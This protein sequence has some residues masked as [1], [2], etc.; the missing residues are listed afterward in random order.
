MTPRPG[1]RATDAFNGT[2]Q[3]YGKIDAL[4]KYALELERTF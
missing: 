1:W 2:R 3:Y 4:G